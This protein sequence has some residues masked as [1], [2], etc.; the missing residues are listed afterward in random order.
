MLELSV[1]LL[2]VVSKLLSLDLGKEPGQYDM[3]SAD[4]L[5]YGLLLTIRGAASDGTRELLLCCH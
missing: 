2:L 1:L 3:P 4:L 5:P